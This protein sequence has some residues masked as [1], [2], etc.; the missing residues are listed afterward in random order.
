MIKKILPKKLAMKLYPDVGWYR[1]THCT[2]PLGPEHP[3]EID[4][5]YPTA[6]AA[7]GPYLN[8]RLYFFSFWTEFHYSDP[9]ENEV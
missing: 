8:Y 1:Y 7:L 5:P 9:R 3:V 4:G 2:N 6:E